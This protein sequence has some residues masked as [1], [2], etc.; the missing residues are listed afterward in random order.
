VEFSTF[1]L[2]A[3]APKAPFTLKKIGAGGKD[4]S[5]ALK[6]RRTCIFAG[7]RVDTPIYEGELLHAGDIIDGPAI[8]EERTTTVVIPGGFRC[9]V[10]ELKNYVLQQ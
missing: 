5:A 9:T 10:D 7:T 1:R 6:R 8:I 2:K 4:A 3:S